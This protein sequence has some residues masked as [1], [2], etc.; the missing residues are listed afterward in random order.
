MKRYLAYVKDAKLR[1][2]ASANHFLTAMGRLHTEEVVTL[3]NNLS[4]NEY[5]YYVLTRAIAFSFSLS[6]LMVVKKPSLL[7]IAPPFHYPLWMTKL[8]SCRTRGIEV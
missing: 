1:R 3:L 4:N 7:Q 2:L 6:N 5:N 8:L